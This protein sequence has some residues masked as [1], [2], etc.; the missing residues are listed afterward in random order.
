MP[1]RLIQ[2]VIPE[3][4]GGEAR[5]LLESQSVLDL[6]EDRMSDARLMIRAILLAENTESVTDVLQKTFSAVDGFRLNLLPVEAS[7]PRPEP[8][9]KEDAN[10]KKSFYNKEKESA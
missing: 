9:E 3:E 5:K 10:K 7:I 4:K 1:L 8:T 2:L 6:W